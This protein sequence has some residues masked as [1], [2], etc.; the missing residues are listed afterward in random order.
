MKLFETTDLKVVN[1]CQDIFRL[2]H[3]KKEI[4]TFAQLGKL[5]L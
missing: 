4:F 5:D 3:I 1:Y 2:Q